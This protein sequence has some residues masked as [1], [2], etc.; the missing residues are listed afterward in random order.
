MDGP[1][2]NGRPGIESWQEWVCGLRLRHWPGRGRVGRPKPGNG[3]CSEIEFAEQKL[4]CFAPPFDFAV[5]EETRSLDSND[6]Q[7]KS[8]CLPLP[9]RH[10]V[11][12]KVSICTTLGIVVRVALILS[13]KLSL[14]CSCSQ[15]TAT[16]DHLASPLSRRRV[17]FH[18][19]RG[20]T[21]A[22]TGHTPPARTAASGFV[23]CRCT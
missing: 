11:V 17:S 6:F 8:R 21:Q 7:C 10:A 15:N 23:P 1:I 18:R 9:C 13:P 14:V 16:W 12:I 2:K 4:L 3:Q 19:W 5:G 22:S 20:H